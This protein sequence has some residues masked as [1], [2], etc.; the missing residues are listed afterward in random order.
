MLYI[1]QRE[2]HFK[3]GTISTEDLS[4]ASSEYI[5][6][7]LLNILYATCNAEDEVFDIK[8]E[9]SDNGYVFV[10]R[11]HPTYKNCPYEMIVTKVTEVNEYYADLYIDN[12]RVF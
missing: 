5:A 2:T 8:K 10:I 12:P 4:V 6:P 9:T 11:E 3:D 7:Y 1:K